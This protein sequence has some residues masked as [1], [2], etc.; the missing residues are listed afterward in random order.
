[1]KH[2]VLLALGLPFFCNAQNAPVDFEAGGFGADFTWTVFENVENPALEIIENPSPDAINGSTTVAK[3]TANAEGAPWA[4]CETMHGSDIGSF[5]LNA[6]TSTITIHVWKS[7]ISDVGIKLVEASSASL[8]EIKIANTLTNQWEELTYDFSSMEGILYDQI[9][10]FPDFQDRSSTN[11][12]YFDNLTFG[13]TTPMAAPMVG[14]P[15]PTIDES[16]VISL[17]SGV[18]TDVAVDTWLTEW[19]VAGNSE[20]DIDANATQ[21]YSGL[22]YAGIETVAN[23]LDLTEMTTVHFNY[24]TPNA[25]ELR[26][27]LVDF[28]ADGAF[29]GDDDSEHEIVIAAPAQ[30]TWNTVALPLT[31]F[32]GLNAQANMAQYILSANPSGSAVVYLDNLYFSKPMPDGIDEAAAVLPNL[33]PNPSASEVNL[34]GTEGWNALTVLNLAGAEVARFNAPLPTTV[35]LNELP[36]GTYLL[37]FENGKSTYTRRVVIR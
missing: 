22:N 32:T 3:F 19:S 4:G 29:E 17:Y 27:K 30:E 33:F 25:T 13:E 18:Y 34:T 12:C 5:T 26:F 21:F 9:V 35:H 1:M 2:L 10:V 14:A 24:W 23:T 28:G 20:L 11:I 8:G 6:E 16:L 31:D 37:V 36:Q 15:N 7:V